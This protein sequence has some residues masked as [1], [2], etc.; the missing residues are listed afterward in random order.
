MFHVHKE[1]DSMVFLQLV[2]EFDIKE[3]VAN[4]LR[5]GL[6]KSQAISIFRVYSSSLQL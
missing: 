2:K 1:D 5:F 3:A 6:S 4:F